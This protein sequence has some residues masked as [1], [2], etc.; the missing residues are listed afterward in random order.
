MKHK[1]KQKFF[2]G[3]FIFLFLIYMVIFVSGSSGYF[4]FRNYKKMSLTKEKIKQ[5]EEDIKAGKKIDLTKYQVNTDLNYSNNLSNI[6][7]NLSEGV[8]DLVNKGVT[9]FFDTIGKLAKE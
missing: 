7:F 2:K 9:G 4:E 1:K 8:S 6:G 3:L 5:Y